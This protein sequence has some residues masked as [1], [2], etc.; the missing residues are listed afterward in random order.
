[1][2]TW[3]KTITFLIALTLSITLLPVNPTVA[4]A[5]TQTW[6]TVGPSAISGMQP[7]VVRLALDS[8]DTPYVACTDSPGSDTLYKFNGAGWET[9]GGVAFSTYARND[10]LD[11]AIDSQDIPYVAYIKSYPCVSMYS[12]ETWTTLPSA[13]NNQ[14]RYIRLALDSQ[15]APYV[16]FKEMNSFDM[17]TYERLTLRKYNSTAGAWETVGNTGFSEQTVDNIC[18]AISP[19][20]KPY[21]AYRYNSNVVIRRWNGESWE[22]LG[23]TGAG[24][25]IN[26]AFDKE[27]VLYVSFAQYDGVVV[28]QYKDATWQQIGSTSVFNGGSDNSLAIDSQ[29]HPVV[30]YRSQNNTGVYKIYDGTAWTAVGQKFSAGG[31]D[32]ASLALGKYDQPYIACN[33]WTSSNPC[34]YT[35][36]KFFDLNYAAGEHG[37]LSGDDTQSI[38]QG[39]SGTEV[40]AVPDE[41]YHFVKWDDNKTSAKRTETNVQDDRTYTA[42]FAIDQFQLKYTAGTGGRITGTATQTVDY[43]SSG[44][45]VT[46]VPDAGY[47]FTGWDDGKQTASRTDTPVTEN[48]TVKASFDSKYRTLTFESLGSTYAAKTIP[49]NTAAG[50]NW[51]T[52]P[53]RSGYTFGGWFTGTNGT[54]TQYTS[55]TLIKTDSTLHAKWIAVTQY[56]IK[57][58][59]NST[60]YGKVTGAGK[61]YIG[62]A[63]TLRATPKEG[64][65]FVRWLEG[66]TVLTYNTEYTFTAS[67]SRTLK[68][69]FARIATPSV[70]ATARGYDGITLSWKAVAAAQGYEIYRATGKKGPF[71][72][73][74]ATAGT[75][76]TDTGL[77]T[78]KTYYYKVRVKCTSGSVTT[79]G[80]YSTV[81]YATPALLKPAQIKA[82]PAAG[83]ATLTWGAVPGATGYEVYKATSQ[84]GRYSLASDQSA[85]TF[86]QSGLIPGK[87]VYYKVRAYRM[88]GGVKVYSSFSAIVKAKPF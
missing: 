12:A 15:D 78:G 51:P 30:A 48:K 49:K 26:L 84:G 14:A 40:T 36:E 56:T 80:S 50:T 54:G 67:K 85:T 64:Y 45:E 35:C 81:R 43:G 39:G 74:T 8:H 19:D 11:L 41:H 65:R 10:A 13:S 66:R 53:V 22:D 6:R 42:S 44:T 73:L 37:T 83:S 52:N 77:N 7:Y 4:Y 1:M 63:V 76:Y 38:L 79:H 46:A 72:Y 57:A 24:D 61:Y 18:L 31:M 88:A 25:C 17:G 9:V 28:W 68:A 69:E 86:N 70:K 82:T 33:D 60:G 23:A 87:T 58:T 34:L 20:D 21:A 62:T 27:G 5:Y 16:L 75:G 3:R 2:K 29:N 71:S 47:D 55:S 32:R 59:A